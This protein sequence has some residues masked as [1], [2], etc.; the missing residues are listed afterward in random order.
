MAGRGPQSFKKRQREQLRKE[1]QDEKRAKRIERKLQ[2]PTP[3]GE[4]TDLELGLGGLDDLDY[5][6]LE[7]RG[8]ENDPLKSAAKQMSRE[9]A[10]TN[11]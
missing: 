3:E 7:S 10:E 2:G 6:V 1:K 5:D 9:P 4:D 8:I 11:N